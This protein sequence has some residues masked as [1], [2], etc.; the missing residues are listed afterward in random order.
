MITIIVERTLIKNLELMAVI[1]G[2]IM[3][4]I[5]II[6]IT[7]LKISLTLMAIMIN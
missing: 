5:I 2:R 7:N 1:K 4:I 3:T 6:I